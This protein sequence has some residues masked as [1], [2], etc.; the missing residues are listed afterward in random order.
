VTRHGSIHKALLMLEAKAAGGD[1]MT[2]RTGAQLGLSKSTV[3]LPQTLA[4]H[5][6]VNDI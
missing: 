5:D 1:G 2:V 6:F 3:S 4:T